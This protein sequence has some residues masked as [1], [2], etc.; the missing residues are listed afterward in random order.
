MGYRS[1]G[2]SGG[3]W[4]GLVVFLGIILW[5]IFSGIRGRY[6][7]FVLNRRFSVH[8]EEYLDLPTL[9]AEENLAQFEGKVVVVNRVNGKLDKLYFSLPEEIQANDDGE[10]GG[11]V[12]LECQNRQV[13]RYEDGARAFQSHCEVTVV[14][15]G[16]MAIAGQETFVGPAPSFT[17]SSGGDRYGAR[18]VDEIVAYVTGMSE[19]VHGKDFASVR[20]TAEHEEAMATAAVAEATH[21]AQV[22]AGAIADEG[23]RVA[24]SS[25]FDFAIGWPSGPFSNDFLSGNQEIVNGSYVWDLHSNQAG[26]YVEWFDD[27]QRADFFVSVEMWGVDDD[28]AYKQGLFFRAADGNNTFMFTINGNGQYEV[29]R[30]REGQWETLAGPSGFEAI[31]FGGVNRLAVRA[32]GN[33]ITFNING[34]Y[35]GELEDDD[36]QA[37]H[38]GLSVE[39]L[40]HNDA[41]LLAFDNFQLYEPNGAQSTP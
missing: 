11:I 34:V 15:R 37:G 22:D 9:N 18:A 14:E 5:A 30:L 20:A 38:I 3:D 16:K 17:K 19:E 21:Q 25:T 2:M 4:I 7:D 40:K 13:G 33:S 1:G 8:L 6:Q 31:N 27:V 10:V 28:W 26:I 35:L 12:W 36:V 29:Q 23:W 39:L 24:Q 32:V 41:A